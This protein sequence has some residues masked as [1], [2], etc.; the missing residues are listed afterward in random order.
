[1][2]Y[3]LTS[4]D[5]LSIISNSFNNYAN[6]VLKIINNFSYSVFSRSVQTSV[7]RIIT[8]DRLH[9]LIVL[10]EPSSQTIPAE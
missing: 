1:M 2:S 8:Y 9:W 3:N 6:I 10:F 5:E 4:G 7:C